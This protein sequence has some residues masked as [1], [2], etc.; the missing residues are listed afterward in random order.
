MVSYIERL[1]ALM[2]FA[3]TALSQPR[4][5]LRYRPALT[6]AIGRIPTPHAR[7]VN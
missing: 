1:L 5:N 4:Q 6:G 7:P 2:G 3:E